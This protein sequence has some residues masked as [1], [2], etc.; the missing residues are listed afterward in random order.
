[1][2]DIMQGTEMVAL[3]T[4]G[5][6][7]ASTT[8]NPAAGVGL[9]TKTVSFPT[10]VVSICFTYNF[11]T[12]ESGS[13]PYLDYGDVTV[14]L[15]SGTAGTIIGNFHIDTS[16][17]A[18]RGPAS[19][20]GAFTHSSGFQSFSMP[21]SSTVAAGQLITIIASAPNAVDC[22]VQSAL[23]LDNIYAG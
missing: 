17:I 21:L 5:Q 6:S 2:Y 19:P 10:S 16:M 9:L 12:S 4:I 20:N 3:Q 1:M 8:C 23:L 22:Q 11:M 15:G 13:P 18:P 7:T 14:R